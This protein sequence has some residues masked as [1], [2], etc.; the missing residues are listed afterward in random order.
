MIAGS[1]QRAHGDRERKE[2]RVEHRLEIDVDREYAIMSM[3]VTSMRNIR[4]S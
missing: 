3:R 4:T 2:E 1:S